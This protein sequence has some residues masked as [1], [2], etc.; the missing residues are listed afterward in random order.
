M[1]NEEE[2]K[3]FL[4]YRKLGVFKTEEEYENVLRSEENKEVIQKEESMKGF[5]K[6]LSRPL[7]KSAVKRK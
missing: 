7:T 2:R 5:M 1:L 4:D 6:T 3:K